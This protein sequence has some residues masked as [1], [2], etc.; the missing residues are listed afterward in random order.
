MFL[1]FSSATVSSRNGN[2]AVAFLAQFP[3]DYPVFKASLAAPTDRPASIHRVSEDILK[4][5]FTSLINSLILA[6]DD[7]HGDHFPYSM[8]TISH[9]C[10]HWRDVAYSLA[11]LWCFIFIPFRYLIKRD[12][13]Y[14]ETREV[15]VSIPAALIEFSLRRAKEGPLSVFLFRM[16]DDMLK[17]GQPRKNHTFAVMSSLRSTAPRWR[18]LYISIIPSGFKDFY[19]IFQGLKN[20]SSP[21]RLTCVKPF[22]VWEF[23]AFLTA[24]NLRWLDLGEYV[25]PKQPVSFPHTKSSTSFFERS[26]LSTRPYSP[27]SSM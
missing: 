2:C 23:R 24:V 6:V 17:T 18:E 20:L 19:K 27:M 26:I 8:L 3:T 9:V 11:S 16:H 22:D 15:E 7:Y 21:E 25:R 5:I 12:E 1:S 4:E 10:V 13:D 14:Q